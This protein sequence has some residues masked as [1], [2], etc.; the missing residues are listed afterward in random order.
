[1]TCESGACVTVR[2]APG[3]F[4]CH[5]NESGLGSGVPDEFGYRPTRSSFERGADIADLKLTIWPDGIRPAPFRVGVDDEEVHALIYPMWTD[6]VGHTD[7]PLDEWRALFLNEAS[8][9]PELAVLARRISGSGP[10]AGVSMCRTFAG[11][12]GWV[13][14]PAVG[15][16]DR[17]VGLGRA[18][19]VESF[20]R[21]SATG[22]EILGLGVGAD[23][24]NALGLYRSVGL[25]V[26]RKWVHCSPA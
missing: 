23:N 16:P 26:A 24:E 3:A 7:R 5:A 25:E 11:G 8:F 21:L 14:Q 4:N 20:H 15:Y 9:V 1:M 10:V 13:S 6:V 17:G 19:L 18:L 12:I 2:L 22:V